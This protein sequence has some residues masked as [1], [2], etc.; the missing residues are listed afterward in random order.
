MKKLISYIKNY[1]YYYKAYIITGVL[2]LAVVIY[3]FAGSGSG[4]EYAR[5]AAVISPDYY[6]EEQLAALQAALTEQYG[7][8]GVRVYQVALGELNQDEAVL[9]KLDLDLG[10]GLSDTLLLA[11]PEAFAA[12]IDANIKIS[13][14]VPVSEISFLKGLGFDSL[15]YVTRK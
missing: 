6:S 15:Y 2:A 1:W 4:E 7:S 10:K 11:D 12:A 3:S 9:S 8:F 14:P 5:Y 13:D